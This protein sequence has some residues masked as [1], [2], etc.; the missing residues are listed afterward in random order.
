MKKFCKEFFDKAVQKHRAHEQRLAERHAKEGDPKAAASTPQAPSEDDV[1]DVKMSDDEGE[2]Q[3]ALKRKRD[4]DEEEEAD[5]GDEAS[6][7]PRSST[8]PPPPPPPMSPG[9][10]EDTRPS[11]SGDDFTPTD[12]QMFET[13]PPPPPPPPLPAQQSEDEIKGEEESPA[14]DYPTDMAVGLE[15][16]V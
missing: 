5:R 9:D 4:E 11:Q 6:K 12:K 10:L 1:L 15:E 7:R 13:P 3:G 16:R 14:K 2:A 8:P